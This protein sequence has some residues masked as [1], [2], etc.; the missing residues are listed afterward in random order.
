MYI[1]PD[2]Y[3]FNLFGMAPADA[4]TPKSFGRLGTNLV[5]SCMILAC[6]YLLGIWLSITQ[7]TFHFLL[8]HFILL[9]KTFPLF[10]G[11]RICL[12]IVLQLFTN[13]HVI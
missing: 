10:L 5:D 3:N 11:N 8:L 9:L 7:I 4:M 2:M 13:L 6:I 1:F 12:E